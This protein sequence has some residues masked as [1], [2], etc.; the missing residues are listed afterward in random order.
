MPHGILGGPSNNITP[1]RVDMA[2]KATEPKY[3]PSRGGYYVWLGG[4]QH[5][6]AKGP[7]KD[8][9]TKRLAEQAFHNL[10]LAQLEPHPYDRIPAYAVLNAYAEWLPKNRKPQTVENRMKYLQAASDAFGRT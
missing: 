3:Y 10:K 9:E 7:E 5:L 1:G 4:K 8:A 6:L 2:R